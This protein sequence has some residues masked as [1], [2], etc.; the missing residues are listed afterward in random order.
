MTVH[1]FPVS[2]LPCH[3]LPRPFT[4]VLCMPYVPVA[5]VTEPTLKCPLFISINQHNY[6]FI[7][8]WE[9]RHAGR[10]LT[11]SCYRGERER[12]R[13]RE[14]ET[15]HTHTHTHS[16]QSVFQ[17]VLTVCTHSYVCMNEVS[18]GAC[19]PSS[20]FTHAPLNMNPAA[21][22]THAPPTDEASTNH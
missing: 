18:G 5:L 19:Y 11:K 10:G 2:L 8:P 22:S 14:R 3:T 17:Y 9:N 15:K 12:E 4:P 1:V 6:C 13:E 21:P 20:H 7:Y 16:C